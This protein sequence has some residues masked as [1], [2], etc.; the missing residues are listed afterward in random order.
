MST[1]EMPGEPQPAAPQMAPPTQIIPAGHVTP[2]QD[3]DTARK[4]PRKPLSKQ[5]MFGVAGLILGILLGIAGTATVNAAVAD[6]N[7]KAAAEAEANKPRPIPEAVNKCSL[8]SDTA[9]KVGDNGH[10]LSLDGSGK[11]DYSGLSMT[12][13]NCVLTALN[14]PDS[15]VDQMGTTRALDGTLKD[16]FSSFN[17]SWNYHPDNGLNVN[18]REDAK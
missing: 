16:S 12:K 1:P 4:G 5:L 2:K 7:T 18:I 10:S 13:I 8:V 11:K 9:A 15:I 17:I 3:S 6:A 14:V